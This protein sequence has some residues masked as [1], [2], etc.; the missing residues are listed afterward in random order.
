MRDSGWRRSVG[1]WAE[2]ELPATDASPTTMSA[3]VLAAAAV[4]LMMKPAI[5]SR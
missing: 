2:P 1:W 3:C 5:D 4:A